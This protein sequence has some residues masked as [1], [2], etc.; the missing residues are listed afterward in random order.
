MT[1]RSPKTKPQKVKPV[2]AWAMQR[3]NG[4][5]CLSDE[6]PYT[7]V[8]KTK[9]GLTWRELDGWKKVPVLIT[10]SPKPPDGGGSRR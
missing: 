9:R 6:V 8:A 4:S 10:P 5:L 2:K 1:T 3:P 7:L